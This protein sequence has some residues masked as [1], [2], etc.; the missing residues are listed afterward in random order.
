MKKI[1]FCIASLVY[2]PIW[3][4]DLPIPDSCGGLVYNGNILVS[5]KQAELKKKLE[6]KG[7]GI[8]NSGHPITKGNPSTISLYADAEIVMQAK[9]CKGSDGPEDLVTKAQEISKRGYETCNQLRTAVDD[10][11]QVCSEFTPIAGS[12]STGTQKDAQKAAAIIAQQGK[13]KYSS[14]LTGARNGI[15]K[16]DDALE[17]DSK[18][19]GR[20]NREV[21]AYRVVKNNGDPISDREENTKDRLKKQKKVA[22]SKTTE[23]GLTKARE[24]LAQLLAEAN[25]SA[26]K[27]G[28]SLE[29]Y[30]KEKGA[31]DPGYTV[32]TLPKKIEACKKL[33]SGPSSFAEAKKI[34]VDQLGKTGLEARIA[35]E[36]VETKSYVG[37]SGGDF[38]AIASSASSRDMSTISPQ[39]SKTRVANKADLEA[40]DNRKGGEYF[41]RFNNDPPPP[42][43]SWVTKYDSGDG[44]KTTTKRDP[45]SDF[46][47]K[48]FWEKQN[49]K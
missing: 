48:T 41:Q 47:A 26:R 20:P 49:Q 15:D 22:I 8:C 33:V 5:A 16:V 10:L 19:R 46:D 1:Y 17:P 36:Q 6:Y 35:L 4:V 3:A 25:A 43:N 9:I 37:A 34:I 27:E 2:Q 21:Q 13:S 40:Y 29:N 28:K 32:D 12:A 23:E 38:T 30:L 11:A 14:V 42:A 44:W 7:G 18:Y 31:I 24:R 45:A 39:F